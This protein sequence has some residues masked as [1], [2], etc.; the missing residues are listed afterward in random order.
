MNG[1]AYVAMLFLWQSSIGLQHRWRA[2]LSLAQLVR[3][4]E[5]FKETEQPPAGSLI[6]ND[7]ES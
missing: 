7:T 3:L 6:I 5:L 2:A 4:H 1:A